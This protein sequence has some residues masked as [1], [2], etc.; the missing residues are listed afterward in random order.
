MHHQTMGFAN[1]NL[2]P[3]SKFLKAGGGVHR[4]IP[5]IKEKCHHKKS[6]GNSIPKGGGGGG[7]GA[8]EGGAGGCGGGSGGGGCGGGGDGNMV[9]LPPPRRPPP[10]YVDRRFGDFHDL[11]R[12]GLMPS[13]VYQAKFGK[14]PAYLIKRIRDAAAQEELFRDE[15]VRKQPLCRYVTQEERAELLGVYINIYCIILF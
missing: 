8:G 3:P 14:L 6:A 2:N 12:S 5:T 4:K 15:Q 11:K 9:N 1:T 13:Y 7:S 10:R